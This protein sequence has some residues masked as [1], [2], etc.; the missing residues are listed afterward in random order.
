LRSAPGVGAAMMAVVSRASA[1][2]GRAGLI[3]LWS[4]AAFGL[5]TI[6][7]GISRSLV[8]SLVALLLVGATDM[9][10]VI[11][12][13]DLGADRHARR[14]ARARERGR[15]AVYWSVERTG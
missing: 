14:D 12:R 13:G 6:L 2:R 9:V 8:L 1:D 15:H 4:V 10:S 11:I 7:F 5:F 3:M